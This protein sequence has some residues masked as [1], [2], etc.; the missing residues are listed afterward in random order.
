MEWLLSQV[1]TDDCVSYFFMTFFSF[2]FCLVSVVVYGYAEYYLELSSTAP[3]IEEV[4][5]TFYADLYDKDGKRPSNETYAWVSGIYSMLF[6]LFW[7][8]AIDN[9]GDESSWVVSMV[10]RW[11]AMDKESL[12]LWK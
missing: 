2:L 7:G 11:W 3:A 4:N 10:R 1:K 12:I 5:V 6:C 9:L 8:L